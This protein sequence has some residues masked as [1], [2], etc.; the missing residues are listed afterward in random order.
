MWPEENAYN[1]NNWPETKMKIK[2]VVRY[3]EIVENIEQIIKNIF[4]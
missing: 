3:Q 2:H 1:F 4:S